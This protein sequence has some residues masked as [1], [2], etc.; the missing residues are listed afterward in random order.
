[1]SAGVLYALH[2]RTLTDIRPTHTL[3]GCPACHHVMKTSALPA[4]K[5]LRCLPS[6]IAVDMMPMQVIEQEMEARL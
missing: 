4:V 1:M 3:W 5:C 2:G 6:G